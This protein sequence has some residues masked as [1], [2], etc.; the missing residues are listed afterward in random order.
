MRL[1]LL[2]NPIARR[3]D[4]SRPTPSTSSAS[5][6]DAGRRCAKTKLRLSAL[7]YV[8]RAVA[9]V[10][11]SGPLTQGP[12][13]RSR[14]RPRGDTDAIG[15]QEVPCLRAAAARAAET[16]GPLG[17]VRRSAPPGSADRRAR[18]PSPGPTHEE[19]LHPDGQVSP[20]ARPAGPGLAAALTRSRPSTRDEARLGSVR[21]G[22]GREFLM[23][24]SVLFDTPPTRAPA[25]S[26]H[27]P[28]PGV[29][30]GSSS[31]RPG[32]TAS[33]RGLRRDGRP[34][35]RGVPPHLAAA[36]TSGRLSELRLRCHRGWP[37]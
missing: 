21:C 35:L 9:G 18:M 30:S 34:G 8:R 28:P 4:P 14:D 37:R 12:G 1:N 25:E 2:S 5:A 22:C 23:K 16:S 33:S 27:R 36:G 31:A 6:D 19:G 29:P 24:H 15:F 20:S 7:R 26:H 10:L 3:R 17:R 32:L 13:E 11:E